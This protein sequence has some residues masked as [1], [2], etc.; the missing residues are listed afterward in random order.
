M[1]SALA[2][3][4]GAGALRVPRS[5]FAPIKKTNDLLDVRSDNYIL[6]ADFQVRP[7]PARILPPMVIDLDSRYFGF[8][9]QLEAR[10]PAGAPSL[11]GCE[12]LAVR[13][14]IRFGRDVVLT[15]VVEM[16]NEASAPIT[17]PDGAHISGRWTG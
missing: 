1:G 9:D 7:N 3:F 17:V 10:F 6:T 15:G 4:P 14:D 13:G 11:L 16:D 12:R 5:R 2:V 8:V